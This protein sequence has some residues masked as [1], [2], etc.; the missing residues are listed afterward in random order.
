MTHDDDDDDVLLSA[1]V[2]IRRYVGYCKQWW[3]HRNGHY[4]HGHITLRH[5]M[6]I[7]GFRYN[8]FCT[9]LYNCRMFAVQTPCFLCWD[10][11]Q[12]VQKMALVAKEERNCFRCRRRC[13]QT[14]RRFVT[15]PHWGDPTGEP[16]VLASC[17]DIVLF[18]ACRRPDCKVYSK[19][20]QK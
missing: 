20:F 11:R 6:A 14:N 10:F 9:K 3:R 5:V 2:I 7:N 19:K 1:L 8:T 15:G 12:F 18:K 13:P 4:G 16:Q 17:V